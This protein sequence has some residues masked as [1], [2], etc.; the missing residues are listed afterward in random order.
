MKRLF[1]SLVTILLVFALVSCSAPESSS[2]SSTENSSSSSEQST[3]TEL[4]ITGISANLY[5]G[6]HPFYQAMVY[7]DEEL[8]E[9][10]NNKYGL[11]MYVSAQLGSDTEMVDGV[12]NGT[13]KFILT[14][15]GYFANVADVFNIFDFPYLFENSE[16][17]YKTLDSEI[18]DEILASL[19]DY[20]MVG[21]AWG[22]SGFRNLSG[23]KIYTTPDQLKGVKVRTMDIP[24]HIEAFNTLGANATPTAWAETFTALQQGTIDC[25]EN[26]NMALVS[27][28]LYEVQKYV[29]ITEHLYTP[30][31][32]VMNQ[33]YFNSL[34]AEDQTA[35][36]EAAVAAAA[37]QRVEAA[38]QN[39][40]A[41][42]EAEEV[43]GM[44]IVRDID[45]EPWIE[46]VQPMYDKYR[47]Q[48]GDY[49]SRIQA[50]A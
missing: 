21:L 39:D 19:S 31:A 45:K 6:E 48:Y 44:T 5:N 33:D 1:L 37:R 25:Q 22:E 3:E 34:P 8:R 7:F 32:Y 15:S 17:A 16:H 46:A 14:S 40:N 11:D 27:S 24:M 18:G 20:G 38:R 26:L 49:F 13:Y 50:L 43:Y 42:T 12:M 36:R 30:I 28:N 41:L 2:T 47:D 4:W 10:T 23:N 9:R 35:I 29:M